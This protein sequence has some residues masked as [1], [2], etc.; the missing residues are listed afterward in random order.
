MNRFSAVSRAT[1]PIAWSIRL[2]A[3]VFLLVTFSPGTPSQVAR[4]QET[5][6]Q[7]TTGEDTPEQII[8]SIHWVAGP[9]TVQ[10]GDVATLVVPPHHVF[11]DGDDTRKFQKLMENITSGQE[12]GMI[13]PFHDDEIGFGDWIAL[14]EFNPMGYVKDNEKDDLD[15]D[16]ILKSIK[17]GN[18]AANKERAKLGWEEMEVIGWQYP[19]YY[20]SLTHNLEWAVKGRGKSGGGESVNFNTRLLGRRGVME[21]TLITD[22]DTLDG[23][24]PGFKTMLAGYSFRPGSR[25]AEFTKGDKIAEYGLA[26][27]VG[28][29]ATAIAMKSGLFKYLWKGLVV[30]AG[31]LL[32]FLKKVWAKIRGE[33]KG[34][35][36]QV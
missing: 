31:A 25:Y 15:A 27:L 13:L 30:G 12:L 24:V 32:V 1:E 14:F 18:D 5:P 4:A 20:D 21:V 10:L 19:P 9:D 17:E 7:N 22:P 34:P 28:G 33:E 35:T 6:A 3:L 11:A 8:A 2:F 23:V 29:G 26:A 16:A 36:G